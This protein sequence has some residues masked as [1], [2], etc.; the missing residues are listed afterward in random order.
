MVR[1]A[2][3]RLRPIALQDIEILAG[4]SDGA[5]ACAYVGAVL[6]KKRRRY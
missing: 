5:R 3:S 1:P 2:S 6:H 4:N